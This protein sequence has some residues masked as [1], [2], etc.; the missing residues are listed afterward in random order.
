MNALLTQFEQATRDRGKSTALYED[1]DA[2]SMQDRELIQALEKKVNEDSNYPIPEGFTK[3]IEK[4]PI[5]S[6]KVA[7]CAVKFFK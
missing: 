5:Y 4:T 7:D 1:P 3:V 2:S 6:Y